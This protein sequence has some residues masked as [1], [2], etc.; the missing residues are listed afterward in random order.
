VWSLAVGEA[1]IGYQ[2]TVSVWREAAA[3]EAFAY[4][5]PSHRDVIEKTRTTGWY[6]EDLFARFSVL[7]A[8]GTF[9]GSPVEGR[10]R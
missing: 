8:E 1:P 7:S 10:G 2:G 9:D 5:D 3:L 4:G 6:A